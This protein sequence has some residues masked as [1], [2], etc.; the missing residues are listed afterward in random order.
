MISFAGGTSRRTECFSSAG[1]K[2]RSWEDDDS[3]GFLAG[4]C[5]VKCS[6]APVNPTHLIAF[7]AQ[8]ATAYYLTPA[9]SCAALGLRNRVWLPA[10]CEACEVSSS[11]AKGEPSF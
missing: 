8:A 11:T 5:G 9:K 10:A 2:G 1:G 6:K 3:A 7:V 4:D